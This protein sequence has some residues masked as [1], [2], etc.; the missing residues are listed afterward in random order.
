MSNTN[1]DLE[2]FTINKVYLIESLKGIL[3][4]PVIDLKQ[5]NAVYYISFGESVCNLGLNNGEISWGFWDAS[6]YSESQALIIEAVSKWLKY[7]N[8]DRFNK[9]KCE[10]LTDKIRL[11]LLQKAFEHQ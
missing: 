10:E 5:T 6:V 8:E 2:S 7:V 4:N 11:E 3:E 9:D 1:I